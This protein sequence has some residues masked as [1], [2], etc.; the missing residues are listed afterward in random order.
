MKGSEVLQD[1]FGNRIA[2]IG[3]IGSKQNLRDKFG[4]RLGEYDARTNRTT[5][6]HG[7]LVGTGNRLVR[8]LR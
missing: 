8:L 6:K 3:T 2:E 4:N 1:K 5:D 7:N